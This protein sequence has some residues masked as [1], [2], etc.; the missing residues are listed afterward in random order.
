MLGL[1]R[2]RDGA[3]LLREASQLKRRFGEAF[4]MPQE[5]FVAM[6]LDGEKRQVR[7][8]SSNPG[9]CLATGIVDA[10]HARDVASRL[11]ASD[12]FSGWGVR[13]LSTQ[14]PSY[15]PLSYQLGSVWPVEN[16]SI[17]FGLKRYGFDELANE[18][19][20]GMLS[21]SSLFPH[22]RLPEVLGGYPRDAEHPHPGIYPRS[23]SPQAWSASA[24]SLF[25]QAMLGIRPF[26]PLR[27]LLID[28]DLPP[29][30]PDLTLRNLQ[31]GDATVDLRFHRE[32][33]GTTGWRVLGRR[34]SVRVLRQPPESS[35]LDGP[36]ARA[37][38]FAASLLRI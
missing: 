38:D 24:V 28:P 17:A 21:A 1:H 12:M 13:T 10:D 36:G 37:R 18:V 35:V 32:R 19:V 6:A 30:L 4:W 33:D 11:M 31:V 22:H 16:A 9:H 29:W 8:I 20:R 27:L 2:F 23:Q 3:R 7:T 5:R 25:V 15:N 34:G 14:H 26:A